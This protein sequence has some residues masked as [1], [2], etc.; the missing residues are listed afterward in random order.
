MRSFYFALIG[1]AVVA[2]CGKKND[3]AAQAAADSARRDIA[4]TTPDSTVPLNDAPSTT[5]KVDT[6]YLP[7]SK[8][9]RSTSPNRTPTPPRSTPD[10]PPAAT[11][12]PAPA[13][14]PE[15]AP[16]PPP[17]ASRSLDVGTVLE[18]RTTRALNSRTTKAGETFTATLDEAV[19]GSNGRVVIPAG[20]E[21]TFTVVALKPA[22]NKSDKDGTINFRATSVVVNGQSSPIDA[23]VTYVEH[24][25]K[26][27]GVGTSEAAKV[28]VGAVAGAIIGKVV[29]GGT[30]AA[31]GGVVGGAAGAAV[32]VETADRDVVIPIGAK[33][34]IALRS[35]FTAEN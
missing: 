27:R 14:S 7:Q 29:G 13:P 35:A 3:Q 4:L 31:A 24:T 18:T 12:A 2:G 34:R 8:A 5:G 26:G 9:P 10:Q 30:G 17:R 28:G 15:P 11:P 32:A 19:T 33:I 23:D 25:L 22:K 1:A 6:V 21:V 16:A 20:A